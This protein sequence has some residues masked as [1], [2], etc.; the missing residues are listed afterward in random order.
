MIL[1]SVN[2]QIL[3]TNVFNILWAGHDWMFYFT[4]TYNAEWFGRF[5]MQ[6]DLHVNGRVH[7]I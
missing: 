6:Q 3:N 2:E 4:Y 5:S 7:V 1:K